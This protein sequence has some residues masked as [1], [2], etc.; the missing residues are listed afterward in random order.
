MDIRQFITKLTPKG[1]A[2]V[3]GSVA[4]AIVFLMLVMNFASAKSYTTLETE[5][6]S[7]PDGQDHLDARRQ[8]D[9]LPDP[10]RR[11]RP[12]R[13]LGPGQPGADRAGHRRPAR[14]RQPAARLR[15]A[16]QVA[17]R[18]LELPAA[19]HLPAR[20]R[21]SARPDDRADPGRRLGH[22]EPRAAQPA[23]PAVR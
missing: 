23:G 5:S 20:A 16:Q 8:G 12:G 4:A 13:R 9:R 11:H 17:A 6:G 2:M 14:R 22:R 15:A 18:R 7:G 1:W 10:E 19:D 3:G 21:G